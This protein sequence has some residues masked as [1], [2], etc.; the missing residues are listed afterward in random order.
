M[1]QSG[2]QHITDDPLTAD[3][4]A[5]QPSTAMLTLNPKNVALDWSNAR[6]CAEMCAL[7]YNP[8]AWPC[9]Q[10]NLF[11]ITDSK[12]DAHALVMDRGN[13]IVVCFRGSKDAQDYIQDGKF[14]MTDLGWFQGNDV[15]SVHKGFLEDFDAINSQLV[16]TVKALLNGQSGQ[17]GRKPIFITGHSLGAALATLCAL[18]FQYQHFPVAGVYTF[19]SPRVGNAAFAEMYDELLKDITFRVIDQNDIVPRVPPLA[20]GY[21]HV[22]NCIFIFCGFGPVTYGVNPSIWRR[23][24]SNVLGFGKAFKTAHDVLVTDHH[25]GTYQANMKMFS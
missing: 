2:P 16:Q 23:A 11:F 25:I 13:C 17:S 7:I 10:Q 5:L 8:P 20:N 1:N 9:D 22:G 6:A 3:C 24:W 4:A 18:E 12:T 14:E 15:T 21:R 19:G